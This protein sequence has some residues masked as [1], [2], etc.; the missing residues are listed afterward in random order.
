MYKSSLGYCSFYFILKELQG[1][2]SAYSLNVGQIKLGAQSLMLA[3]SFVH[4]AMSAQTCTEKRAKMAVMQQA[5]HR[6]EIL[7]FCWLIITMLAYV[8]ERLFK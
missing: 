7:S 2:F 1:N 5:S 3:T 6:A 8:P 4:A